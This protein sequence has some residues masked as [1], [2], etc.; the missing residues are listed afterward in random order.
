[1]KELE[2]NGSACNLQLIIMPLKQNNTILI[3]YNLS[4]VVGLDRHD[5]CYDT[6]DNLSDRKCAPN[7]KERVI[8][9]Y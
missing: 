1:M 4:F 3:N 6:F 9:K 8:S 2:L 7:K 5:R